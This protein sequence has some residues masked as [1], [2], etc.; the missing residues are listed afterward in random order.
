MQMSL[1]T[2]HISILKKACIKVQY[3]SRPLCFVRVNN[4][5]LKALNPIAFYLRAACHRDLLI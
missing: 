4:S 3:L 5:I 2:S 1:F